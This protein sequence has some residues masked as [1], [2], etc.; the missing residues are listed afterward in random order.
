MEFTVTLNTDNTLFCFFFV[1][2]W[3][4]TQ[5]MTAV[6]KRELIYL[7]GTFG[8]ASWLAGLYFID[9][10][11]GG[12]AGH[13]LNDAIKEFK[14]KNIKLW[15]F[16]EGTRRNTGEIHDFKKGAF[17][18]AIQAQVPIVPVVFSSYKPFFDLKKKVFNEG[19]I[20]ITV[21]PEIS[22][23]GMTA[24]DVDKLLQ[25]TRNAMV[26]KYHETSA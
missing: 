13:A 25:I 3:H 18:A 21:L 17:H 5:K 7:S 15:V 23:A 9:R 11:S 24:E 16:P 8:V 6:A 1:D 10:K 19:K 4:V 20:I 2:I 22:T 26:K 14:K 12:R